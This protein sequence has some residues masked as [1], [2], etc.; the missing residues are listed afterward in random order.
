MKLGLYIGPNEIHYFLITFGDDEVTCKAL[1]IQV[2]FKKDSGIIQPFRLF[3]YR[4]LQLG[5]QFKDMAKYKCVLVELYIQTN[6]YF[7]TC[8][9][10]YVRMFVFVGV[11]R[12]HCWYFQSSLVLLTPTPFHFLI[13]T[14]LT[15]GHHSF[16]RFTVAGP[17]VRPQ[18]KGFFT[19]STH[20][21]PPSSEFIQKHCIECT[22]V[23][24]VPI[25]DQLRD[26]SPFQPSICWLIHYSFII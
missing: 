7:L 5:H 26:T 24:S 19:P 8:T 4:I 16:W 21:Q 10:M 17:D 13:I 1:L 18:G 14:S 12:P 23:F 6:I 3:I 25:F 9:C 11:R 22:D 2:H 15:A 20:S